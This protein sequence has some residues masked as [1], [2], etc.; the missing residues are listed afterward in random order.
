MQA[1]V[2]IGIQA[3]GKSS[4]YQA[5]FADTHVRINL[6]MLRT[7]HREARMLELCCE[8]RQPFVVDNTNATR[9]ERA[10]YIE[11]ERAAGLPVLGYYFESSIEL[12]LGLNAARYRHS[13]RTSIRP[14]I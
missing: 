8:T 9:A 13:E 1:I 6:D 10:V 7:R 11:A 5:R 14:T 4:F 2:L 3:T 12:A